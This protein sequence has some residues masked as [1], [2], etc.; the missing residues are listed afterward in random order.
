[1]SIVTHQSLLP[2]FRGPSPIQ[3]AILAGEKETG[4]TIIKM[5]P[6][7]DTG[8]I[9]IQEAIEI[10]K[11]D[12]ALS[13]R[14]LLANVSLK[15]LLEILPKIQEGKIKVIPQDESKASITH[16]FTKADGEIN[17]KKSVKEIDKQIRALFGWPGTF[18]SIDG[19]RLIIHQAHLDN[20]K[21]VLDIVQ[22]EGRQPMPWNDFLRGFKG[23][24]PDWF[25]KIK[26]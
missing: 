10:D 14:N 17:W 18:T 6:E 5:S 9:L 11:Q 15:M 22:P 24:A 23:K 7:F 26:R 3:S 4:V 13:M 20:G 16:K 19:K 25:S 12:N 1:M 21:L 2:K 8:E